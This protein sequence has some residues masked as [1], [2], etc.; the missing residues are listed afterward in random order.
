MP[1]SGRAHL[2]FYTADQ[3]GTFRASVEGIAADG[4][5]VTA[6]TVLSVLAQP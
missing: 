5:P 2:S 6:E 1:A 4:Q 3:A